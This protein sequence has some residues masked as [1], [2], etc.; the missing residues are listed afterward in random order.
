MVWGNASIGKKVSKFANINA[1]TVIGVVND[2]SSYPLR[3]GVD[4]LF[5]IKDNNNGCRHVKLTG[6]D[7]PGAIS[8]VQQEI[9]RYDSEHPFEYFFLDQKYDEQYKADITRNQLLSSLSYVCVFIS[10]LGL[11]GLSAFA[12]V[13]RT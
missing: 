10:L 7:I 6:E 3:N 13:Q 1:G 8:K 2:F 4:P 9:T 11:L 12:A 5:I